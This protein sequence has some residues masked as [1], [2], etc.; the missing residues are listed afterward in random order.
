MEFQTER[1]NEP[2]RDR[3]AQ[4][5]RQIAASLDARDWGRARALVEEARTVAL[6]IEGGHNDLND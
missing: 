2:A 5:N 1:G 3:I 4:L 6:R